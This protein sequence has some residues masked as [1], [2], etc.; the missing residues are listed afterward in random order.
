MPWLTINTQVSD[1]DALLY[2]EML[3][4]IEQDERTA[5]LRSAYA[6]SL[7]ACDA[8]PV[9]PSNL[10]RLT[11]EGWDHASSEPTPRSDYHD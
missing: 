2:E 11:A 7:S 4:Q 10:D 9:H 3:D 5:R 1:A 6:G 8:E